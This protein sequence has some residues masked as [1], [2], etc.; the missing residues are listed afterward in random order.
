[1]EHR[2]AFGIVSSVRNRTVLRLWAVFMTV[3]LTVSWFDAGPAL[4][5][6]VSI[7]PASGPPGTSVTVS[8]SGFI[9]GGSYQISFA[10]GTSYEQILVPT[11]TFSGPT[12]SRTVTIPPIPWGSYAISVISST[13]GTFNSLFKVTPL[14]VLTAST[15]FVGDNVTAWGRGFSA[16]STVSIV[17]NGSTVGLTDSDWYGELNPV[18]F[19][20]PALPRGEYN[21][22]GTDAVVSSSNIVFTIRP[23][24][25][26]SPTEGLVGTQLLLS[27]TGFGGSTSATVYWDGQA[28]ASGLLTNNSGSFETTVSIPGATRG[29]HQVTA[30]DAGQ[31]SS[32]AYFKVR[33]AI[34][35]SPASGSAGSVVQVVGSGFSASSL[36]KLTYNGGTVVTQPPGLGTDTS[37]VFTASFTAP[38]FIA[39]NYIV[40]ANDG[41]ST[42][43]ATFS[44]P[45][46]LTISPT[47]GNVSSEL[48]ANGTGFT[49]GGHIAI[50]Y[51]SQPV[52]TV[53][54]DDAGVFSASFNAPIS[55]AGPHTVSARDLAAQSVVASANFSMES[56]SP[57]LPGLPTPQDGSQTDTTPLFT[58]SPVTDPS[59][60]SYDLQVARDDAFTQLV[61]SKQDL[62]IPQYQV[63]QA[64]T[65]QLTKKDS[66]YYWRVQAV[67]GAGN[68]S[69]WNGVDT[70][71]TLDSTP[72]GVPVL[73]IPANDVQAG[74]Q[75]VFTW[76]EATDPSGVTY[77]VQVALDSDF[78]RMVIARQ[79]LTRPEYQ[80]T[81]AESLLP[82]KKQAPYYWRVQV[83][84]EAS[85]ASGWTTADS[86]YTLDSTPPKTPVTFN[87]PNGSRT[88]TA[89][90]FDWTDVSDPSG[91][92]YDL[93]V[94][95]DS[96]FSHLMVDKEGLKTSEYK[97]TASEE[98][99]ASMGDPP[100]TYYW[101]VNAVDGAKN[102]S[103]WS[104][105]GSFSVSAFR[106]QGW[107]LVVVLVIGTVLV[108]GAGVFI[109]IKIR[110]ARASESQ[111]NRNAQKG[112]NSG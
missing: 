34:T 93:E 60:V 36:I 104:D 91:V 84:D 24:L 82:T 111:S 81:Q 110:P 26:I 89:V 54:A 2:R 56:A 53:T 105:V 49:P 19:T 6:T 41:F 67:D 4:A 88:G 97:L 103:G 65:L 33:P 47:T 52:I 85:N 75:P 57:P 101:R 18:D 63:T 58:W 70:F 22:Y 31:G 28:L 1:M 45:A 68:A 46:K 76:T 95:Q 78:T 12:F 106:L 87:P 99:A 11:T 29:T 23:H 13:H 109:G 39:G 32:K 90:S 20:V 72:P 37:G 38:S 48:M 15:G 83:V 14:H 107:L 108:L 17:F 42:A 16:D 71:Y 8:G 9:G 100:G 7:T 64:E 86:F 25:T 27:G 62:T 66:P 77:D 3:L 102:V 40:S 112:E 59:G 96:A 79:G 5:Q 61:L 98:L 74:L 92:T 80:V 69:G 43:T 10:T 44:V 35:L 21:V 94:A 73:L 50:S 30:K 55:P 51:D